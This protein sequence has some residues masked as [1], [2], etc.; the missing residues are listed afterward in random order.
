ML[1][2]GGE[3]A[4][5]QAVEGA[6]DEVVRAAELTRHHGINSADVLVAVAASGTTPFTLGVSPRGAPSRRSYDWDR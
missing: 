1:L 3:K 5:A 4:M 6:E 2:A